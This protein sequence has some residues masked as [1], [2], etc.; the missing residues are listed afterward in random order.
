MKY[1]L[2]LLGIIALMNVGCDKK[3]FHHE[4]VE[5]YLIESFVKSEDGHCKIDE[6][7]VVTKKSPLIG[8]S[9]IVSYDPESYTFELSDNAVK[10]IKNMELSVHGIPFAIKVD[11]ILIYTGYFWPSYSSASCDWVTINPVRTYGSNQLIV[12]LGYP[13]HNEGDNIPDKRNDKRIIDTFKQD[14]KL[15]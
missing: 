3:D 10:K 8:Y 13:G 1:K 5:L 15:K 6:N 7:T 11:N 9:E 4:K 14:H 12:E 2:L